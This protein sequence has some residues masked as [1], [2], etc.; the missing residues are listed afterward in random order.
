VEESDYVHAGVCPYDA[1]L[2]VDAAADSAGDAHAD[3][4]EPHDAK[5]VLDAHDAR[6][7]DAHDARAPTDA[8]DATLP[9]PDARG[10]DASPATDA[11][12]ASVGKADVGDAHGD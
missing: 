2:P 5:P 3:V 4:R 10:R 8:H 1:G 6:A 12:D 7:A 11:H 9:P